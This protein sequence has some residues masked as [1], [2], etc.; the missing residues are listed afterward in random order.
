VGRSGSKAINNQKI[1]IKF[2]FMTINIPP[3]NPK[4]MHKKI[5]PSQIYIAKS[6]NDQGSENNTIDN[7]VDHN[8]NWGEKCATIEFLI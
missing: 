6:I 2:R 3:F 7:E 4:A 5:Q 1:I 8:Q